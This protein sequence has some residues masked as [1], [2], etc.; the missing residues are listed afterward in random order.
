MP[1]PVYY[2]EGCQESHPSSEARA[3]ESRAS[4][5]TNSA[6]NASSTG[7]GSG[8]TSAL[9]DQGEPLSKEEADRLYEERME[10]EYAKREGGA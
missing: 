5:T 10:E 2:T 4:D 7:F 9:N 1:I 8:Y 3:G 6:S